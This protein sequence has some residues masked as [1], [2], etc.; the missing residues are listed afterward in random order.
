MAFTPEP[1][2]VEAA[3]WIAKKKRC[4]LIAS[5]GAGKTICLAMALDI[6]LRSKL[7]DRKVRVGWL[8]NTLEQCD[9]ARSA[10]LLF[11]SIS[12]FADVTV[13]CAAADC[14]WSCQDVLICDEFHHFSAPSWTAQIAAC[15]GAV[16]GM[17]A[18]PKTGD[19]VRDKALMDFCQGNIFTVSREDVSSR[20]VPAFVTMFDAGDD[21]MRQRIDAEIA[22]A[23]PKRT[24][25]M[26][27]VDP[28]M[29]DGEIYSQVS[30]QVCVEFGIVENDMRNSAFI[31]L[32]EKHQDD[33]VIALV[34]RVEHAQWMAERIGRW[35]V[36]VY[37]AIGKKKRASALA[38]F[39]SGEVK[40]IVAT[41]LADEGVDLPMANVLLLIS[42][43]R[44]E[45]KSIQR[46]GRVLRAAPAKTEGRIY[47]CLDTRHPLMAK[48]AQ[49][50]IAL[51]KKLGYTV[52]MPGARE[53]ELAL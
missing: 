48:H 18:T 39:R 5:A 12:E 47:D 7:R 23:L 16:W 22:A 4:A 19:S 52:E 24:R 30:W 6:A 25:Q 32:A 50:R 17:T 36:A 43:G 51:Y 29:S 14:D 26:R 45:V 11:P 40:C 41:T 10:M 34:N 13:A 53:L 31:A 33:R 28:T 46:T 2:Q 42:G 20:L 44:S 38:A 8:S 1:Y 27:W 3:N 9:Q 15:K 49:K 37:A 21:I 35:A